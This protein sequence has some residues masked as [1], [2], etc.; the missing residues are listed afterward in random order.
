MRR[1]LLSLALALVMCLGLTVPAMAEEEKGDAAGPVTLNMLKN[2][3]IFENGIVRV[4]WNIYKTP[5]FG[6]RKEDTGWKTVKEA[7]VYIPL[8]SKVSLAP[9]AITDNL[10]MVVFTD[11]TQ[12]AIAQEL[13]SYVF[14]VEGSFKIGTYTELKDR[15]V[16]LIYNMD[17]VVVNEPATK[18]KTPFLDISYFDESYEMAFPYGKK[19]NASIPAVLRED[20]EWIYERGVT[21]GTSATT[22]S[23]FDSLTRI[24]LVQM[25]WNYSGK[26]EPTSTALPFED[27]KE[28]DGS[29]KAVCWAYET[30]LIEGAFFDGTL[31]SGT[32][33][34]GMLSPNK[35]CST[36]EAI[37]ALNH[38]F[39]CQLPEAIQDVKVPYWGKTPCLRADLAHFL[40]YA[41]QYSTG[42]LNG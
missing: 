18:L 39:Q 27:V 42:T 40:H 22:F 16:P 14:S 33:K 26:P 20:I 41:Y 12:P 21:K 3:F 31:I 11:Y 35:S 7:T 28:T 13:S 37:N 17:V 2:D 8:G 34:D 1:Q 29:Y 32:L 15:D 36:S 19:G 6:T 23:P 38:L 9:L 10:K 30:G 4:E 25:L 24:Q 5:I